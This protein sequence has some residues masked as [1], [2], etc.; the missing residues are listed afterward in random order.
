MKELINIL[1]Q[2]IKEK[3]ISFLI[4]AIVFMCGLYAFVKVTEH[5][6]ERSISKE[7]SKTNTFYKVLSLDSLL[8]KQ[9]S[10][11][12]AKCDSTAQFYISRSNSRKT[13]L[14]EAKI[15]Y[16]TSI[17]TS[18]QETVNNCSQYASILEADNIDKDSAVCSLLYSGLKKD[19]INKRLNRDLKACIS[20]SNDWQKIATK[21]KNW[22][23]RNE[24]YIAFG[25]G[26]LIG[27]TGFY[28][29]SK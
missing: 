2:A 10:I 4:L 13:S 27:S 3:I 14:K 19:S 7:E 29:I 20:I 5:S 9:D 26:A 11:I 23:E 24:K 25:F 21:P 28:M 8:N 15:K 1:Y 16:G 12:A 22:I 17:D 18:C 6:K